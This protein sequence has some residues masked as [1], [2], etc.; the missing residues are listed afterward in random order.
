[1]RSE[2]WPCAG[3]CRGD[4]VAKAVPTSGIRKSAPL[5]III[6][7]TAAVAFLRIALRAADRILLL[8]IYGRHRVLTE[9]LTII[10]SKP[11]IVV[12]N[13]DVLYGKGFEHYLLGISIWMITTLAFVLLAYRL[14]PQRER[15]AVSGR[16]TLS[17]KAVLM[18]IALFLA[19]GTLPLG[20]SL[21]LGV[22][23]I[24]IGLLLPWVRDEIQRS[25]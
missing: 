14:L 13:G 9:H 2:T 22:F 1:M 10:K 24:M 12:S 23:V 11:D 20:V 3:P 8:F 25:R 5:A 16:Y 21:F 6:V 18:I 19:I 17:G 15:D 4:W 7:V